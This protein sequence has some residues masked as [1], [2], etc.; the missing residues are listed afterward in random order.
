MLNDKIKKL[1]REKK[2]TEHQIWKKKK[3]WR[4][5]IEK[6]KKTILNKK[7]S[8]EWGPNLIDKEIKGGCN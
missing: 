6:E 4:S 3:K 5:E 1:T 2:N 8:K 7:K